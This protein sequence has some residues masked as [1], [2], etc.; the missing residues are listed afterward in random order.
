[1]TQ[2]GYHE[3]AGNYPTEQYSAIFEELSKKIA[4]EGESDALYLDGEL[5]AHA[6]RSL[7]DNSLETMRQH[8]DMR[9]SGKVRLR[10]R[11]V[12][13]TKPESTE[14]PPCMW[15]CF[16]LTGRSGSN[17]LL[18]VWW[19]S[20]KRGCQVTRRPVYLSA[21]HRYE[22]KDIFLVLAVAASFVSYSN[23]DLKANQA[24]S[25]ATLDLLPLESSRTGAVAKSDPKL[26]N[27]VAEESKDTFVFRNSK[28]LKKPSP[29]YKIKMQNI[30][31]DK[32]NL[33]QWY[34]TPDGVNHHVE[35]KGANDTED[36]NAQGSSYPEDYS[37]DHDHESYDHHRHYSGDDQPPEGDHYDSERSHSFFHQGV[38]DDIQESKSSDYEKPKRKK[39]KPCS[40]KSKK[41]GKWPER[42]DTIVHGM[43]KNG[44]EITVQHYSTNSQSISDASTEGRDSSYPSGS[45]TSY[46]SPQ[47]ASGFRDSSFH[48]SQS[49]S[50]FSDSSFHSPRPSGGFIP[51]L[52]PL[53]FSAEHLHGIPKTFFSSQRIKGEENH[54]HL[55]NH[56]HYNPE[57]KK[58]SARDPMES[59]DK[60]FQSL[61]KL[62][63]MIPTVLS[64]VAGALP[65]LRQNLQPPAANNAPTVLNADVKFAEPGEKKG[66]HY[67]GPYKSYGKKTY[68]RMKNTES[69]GNY[70]SSYNDNQKPEGEGFRHEPDGPGPGYP[71]PEMNVHSMGGDMF[72]YGVGQYG[73]D[74]FQDSKSRFPNEVSLEVDKIH[75]GIGFDSHP[76]EHPPQGYSPES[77]GPYEPYPDY[78]SDYDSGRNKDSGEEK[79]S[80]DYNEKAP[81]VPYDQI[82]ANKEQT[83]GSGYGFRQNS[84]PASENP[85]S[86][87]GPESPHSYGGPKSPHP[88]DGPE[89]P[90]PYDGPESPRPYDGPES[91]HSYSGPSSSH[92]YD[93]PVEPHPYDGPDS[94]HPYEG[95][96]HSHGYSDA[97]RDSS[98]E[99]HGPGGPHQVTSY[100]VS[101]SDGGESAKYSHNLGL[102]EDLLRNLKPDPDPLSIPKNAQIIEHFI[103]L[104]PVHYM[105]P[106]IPLEYT[107]GAGF[108]PQPP[109]NNAFPPRQAANSGIPPHPAQNSGFPSHPA[110]NSGFAPHPHQAPS[111]VVPTRN[112]ARHIPLHKLIPNPLKMPYPVVPR[113]VI[114]PNPHINQVLRA[115]QSRT[116]YHRWW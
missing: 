24:A 81:Y 116:F 88:Y 56:H 110:Q 59:Y 109:P 8:S 41:S 50:G 102:D 34:S 79:Y 94:P 62:R 30:T 9:P 7:L 83:Y 26:D 72:K 20:V 108:Q 45:D 11:N 31:D 28:R 87:D 82:K 29:R 35:G 47:P 101:H 75:P 84:P 100:T 17:V 105:A 77:A 90:H 70:P 61:G 23:G 14:I 6:L 103:H 38:S 98:V 39:K 22:W 25:D 53:G 114:H 78:P 64:G 99:G 18:L 49:T 10:V 2:P 107:P 4:A 91:P 37:H 58:V 74:E 104:D 73:T 12:P 86:Y 13:G 63:S 85:H 55:H 57:G 68:I 33:V 115:Y 92:P 40:R 27:P 69:D 89:S 80:L 51:L 112:F 66:Y 1:M 65:N 15:A 48:S 95:P 71:E 93:G 16:S 5:A 97:P 43:S 46:D 113:A 42:A 96:N 52:P 76:Q 67:T 32:Y 3:T 60:I 19:G 106:R 54:F 36:L 44:P 111:M 21:I